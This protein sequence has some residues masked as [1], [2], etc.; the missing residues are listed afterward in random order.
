MQDKKSTSYI[1]GETLSAEAP[2]PGMV[3][4]EI[5]ASHLKNTGADRAD[6]HLALNDIYKVLGSTEL[7]AGRALGGLEVRGI[8]TREDTLILTVLLAVSRTL[9]PDLDFLR[10]AIIAGNFRPE[11]IIAKV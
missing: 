4:Y 5:L 1:H 2:R 8:I 11:E 10:Q 6:S 7:E 3:A 9:G